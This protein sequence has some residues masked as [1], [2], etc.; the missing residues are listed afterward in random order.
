[1]AETSTLTVGTR[2][3]QLARWQTDHVI[4]LLEAARPDLTCAIQTFSTEG[5]RTLDRPL[6]AIGGKGLFTAA[7]ETALRQGAIDIAV[8][9]LKDLPVADPPGL[10]VGAIIGRADVRDVLVSGDSHSL[11]T[12]PAGAIVGTSS[13]RRQAQLLAARPDL[14]VR[15]IRGN[16]ET[17]IRKVMEGAYDAAVLAAAGLERLGLDKQYAGY[18]FAVQE[19]LPAPGQGALA[20]QCRVD[21]APTLALL[22][23]INNQDVRDA[24]TAER[25]FLQALGG[26]CAVPVAAFAQPEAG[27]WR[28]TGLV[29]DPAGA[30]VVRVSDSG[31]EAA[32]L[33]R[34]LAG[35]AKTAGADTILD[36]VKPLRN[37]RIIVTRSPQ[38]ARE[39]AGQLAALGAEPI[40][41]PVITFVAADEASVL[42][43]LE[44]AAAYDWLVFTS[45]NA[46]HFFF[47]FYDTLDA[48]PPLAQVATVGKATA[49]RLAERGITPDFVPDTFTGEALAT[50]LGDLTGKRVLLPR[51]RIGRPEIVALLRE[52]G[53]AVDDVALYDTVTAT[54]TA[55][56]LAE[57]ERG[58]DVVTFTSPSSVRNFRKLLQ[59][60]GRDAD[61]YLAQMQTVCIGPS[62]ADQLAEFGR[63]ADLVPAEYTIDGMIEA[64]IAKP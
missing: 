27:G 18:H 12:L 38:Q 49:E 59:L 52:Q 34:A 33:G 36:R 15:S 20:V 17:R 58:A 56:S 40:I 42:P 39:F 11:A 25:A 46:V 63:A 6:P 61:A 3:S 30:P 24:V 44:D 51:A 8:H 13:L 53:A 16:V 57:L 14:E 55:E 21:D 2:V 43:Y 54:P 26:G 45:A 28:L 48:P 5:D 60:A 32:A 1:M 22:A 4:A 29:A 7:L 35:Q 47:S 10:T 62:T 37:K 19:M 41:F 64:L 50:G 23:L 9:S 31:E